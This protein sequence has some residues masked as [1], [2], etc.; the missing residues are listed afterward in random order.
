MELYLLHRQSRYVAFHA[1]QVPAEFA[2]KIPL[3]SHQKAA[4]Y[5]LAKNRLARDESLLSAVL[6]LAWTFGGGL[7][8]LYGVTGSFAWLGESGS[9][10][11]NLTFFFAF[12]AMNGLLSLPFSYVSTFKIEAAFGFNRMT[13]GLW[14][15][16][17][18]RSS[19]LMLL[20]GLPILWLVLSAMHLLLDSLWWL[21]VWAIWMGFTLLM[22]WVW[23][24]WIAPLF[25]QFKPLEDASLKH[26]IDALMTKTGFH[27]EGLFV[28]DGSK[29]SGHGNAYFT[30]F[31]KNKR[32]VFYDTLLEKLS[33]PQ[34]LAVLAHEL[35]HFHHK[36]ILKRLALMAGVSLAVLYSLNF[37]MHWEGFYS[38]LGLQTPSPVMALVLL[39]LTLPLVT[40]WLSPALSQL[41]RKDE[42]EADVFAAE[43]TPKADLI[44]ALLQL[45]QDN[46]S[47]L[48]P[49][50]LYSA[51]VHSHPPAR[52]RI[53][54]LKSLHSV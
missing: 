29:R 50:P 36:H 27:C 20:L 49:D 12:I 23:P 30:G 48:T 16:D 22:T 47:T 7:N 45:Y 3:E 52:E 21:I 10:A 24:T 39:M 38:G 11:H 34:I 15:K 19:L 2:E 53:R 18:L 6:F 1:A 5:T 9:M 25:N 40:Y 13:L 35:G 37:L 28:M 14:L 46:A 26:A 44:S 33:Q 54:A 42:F 17:L 31:G 51:W 43:Q 4:R 8:A 32:I 41:S